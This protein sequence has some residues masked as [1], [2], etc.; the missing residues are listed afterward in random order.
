VRVGREGL[1]GDAV[2]VAVGAGSG[3]SSAWAGVGKACCVGSSVAGGVL[4]GSVAEL[5]AETAKTSSKTVSSRR[6]G[7]MAILA[8]LALHCP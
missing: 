3:V 8:R 5:Q 6:N 2:R 7:D 4:V 1:V